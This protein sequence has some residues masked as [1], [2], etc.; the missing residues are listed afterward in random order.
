ML[1][2]IYASDQKCNGYKISLLWVACA[3]VYNFKIFL[4]VERARIAMRQ[5]P[6]RFPLIQDGHALRL[7]PPQHQAMPSLRR[8]VRHQLQ[9]VTRGGV[10]QKREMSPLRQGLPPGRLQITRKTMRAQAQVLRVLRTQRPR[11][12]LPLALRRLLVPH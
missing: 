9:V 8:D 2:Y 4:N 1:R 11:Q 10:S 12:L 7:L 5:L 3:T 6:Q